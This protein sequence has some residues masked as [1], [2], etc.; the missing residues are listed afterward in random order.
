MICQKSGSIDRQ[1]DMKRYYIKP[2]LR[3]DCAPWRGALAD[4][5]GELMDLAILRHA[6]RL[7]D[8]MVDRLE[9]KR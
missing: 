2:R 6:R 5:L 7:L 4:S 8:W 1:R 3:E 9:K